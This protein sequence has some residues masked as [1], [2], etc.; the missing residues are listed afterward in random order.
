MSVEPEFVCGGNWLEIMRRNGKEYV[1]RVRGGDC[2][3]IIATINNGDDALLLIEQ[4]R[5]A[6]DSIV[7]ELPAGVCG[8]H[9]AGENLIDAC[10]RELEEETGCQAD[11]FVFLGS[12]PSN[13]GTTTEMS[14]FFLAGHVKVVGEGGGVEDED[15]T[16]HKIPISQVDQWLVEQ[17]RSGKMVDPRVYVGMYLRLAYLSGKMD[18][19]PIPA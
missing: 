17:I 18:S 4:Y 13:A 15:I 9:D 8:D 16:V 6:V 2:V 3:E 19:Q 7:I 5:P 10:G 12:A 11:T 14:N 1:R